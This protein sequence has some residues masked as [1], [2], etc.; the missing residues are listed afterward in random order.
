M[1]E[2]FVFEHAIEAIF[3]EGLEEVTEH[4]TCPKCGNSYIKISCAKPHCRQDLLLQNE[5]QGEGW[6]I[7]GI[8]YPE[9]A[10]ETSCECEDKVRPLKI[11]PRNTP[12]ED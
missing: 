12:K 10:I 9:Y 6:Q 3:N 1:I 2:K 8:V 7:A 4:W 11:I 5:N